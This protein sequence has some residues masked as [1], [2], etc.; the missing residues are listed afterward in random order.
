MDFLQAIALGLIQGLTEFLPISSTAHLRVVPALAGWADPGTAV[1]AVIQLGTLL[2][3]LV[4]FLGDLLVLVKAW[5]KGIL[6]RQPTADPKARLAWILILGTVP[7][8]VAGL[9]F[10]DWI[11]TSLRSLWLIAATLIGLGLLLGWAE[12]AGRREK[13]LEKMGWFDGLLIGLAQALALIPGVSRSGITI[14]TG[15]FRGYQRADAARFSFLL[16]V[17]AVALSGCY[18]LYKLLAGKLGAIPS[19]LWGPLVVATLVAAIS[20]YLAIAGLLRYLQRRSTAV[21]I[22]YRLVFGSAILA[23]L[24]FGVLQP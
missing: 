12:L 9:I 22:V 4:Y 13:T 18:E 8:G 15:L 6:T 1:S 20:G 21:F 10:Q 11:E 23:L 5:G 3:V 16:S 24:F 17:P 14:T 7:I 2:A 19:D